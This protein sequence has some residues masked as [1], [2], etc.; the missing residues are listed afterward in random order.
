MC[1]TPDDCRSQHMASSR[2]GCYQSSPKDHTNFA[3]TSIISPQ[4]IKGKLADFSR[5][6]GIG[7]RRGTESAGRVEW[8]DRSKY[9]LAHTDSRP[10]AF[11]SDCLGQSDFRDERDQQRSESLIQARALWRWRCLEGSDATSL[12]DLLDRQTERQGFMGA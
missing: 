11:E 4:P 2:R 8:K 12:D 9:S 10:C 3:C 1:A 5:S 6:A 7:D